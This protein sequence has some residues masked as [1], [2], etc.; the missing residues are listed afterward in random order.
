LGDQTNAMKILMR[1][2]Q[3]ELCGEQSRYNDLI[4]WGIALQTINAEKGAEP[5]DGT[6]PFQQKHVLLPIPDS[7]KNYNPNVAKDVKNGWN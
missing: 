4:R 3:L 2:R 1:E 5:G 6:Q 7:E